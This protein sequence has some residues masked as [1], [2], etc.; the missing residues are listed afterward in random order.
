MAS[1]PEFVAFATEPERLAIKDDT[2]VQTTHALAIERR[3]ESNYRD[4]AD[5]QALADLGQAERGAKK[6]IYR[7]AVT[8]VQFL[9]ELGD[10]ETFVYD[11][12]GL[13]AGKNFQIVGVEENT[14]SKETILLIRG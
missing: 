8:G 6:L 1:T 11:R 10:T 5:A 14:K 13:A 3:I 4:L 12:F 2:A 9:L 7:F